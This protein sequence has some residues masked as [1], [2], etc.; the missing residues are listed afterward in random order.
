MDWKSSVE[1][2]TNLQMMQ[3]HGKNIGTFYHFEQTPFIALITIADIVVDNLL[4]TRIV[5][6]V[7]DNKKIVLSVI[8]IAISCYHLPWVFWQW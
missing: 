8:F 3:I 6:K 7:V 2:H 5:G 1:I 4:T